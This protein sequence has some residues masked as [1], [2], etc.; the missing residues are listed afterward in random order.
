MTDWVEQ[1]RDVV[2]ASSCAAVG[3]KIG[4]SR[5]AISHIYHERYGASAGR[6]KAAFLDAFG[7]G[8]DCPHLGETIS[9]A[10]CADHRSG[11][12]PTSNPARFK[13]WTACQ[14]CP[15]NPQKRTSNANR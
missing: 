3:R 14:A 5:V 1:L 4:Y 6:I 15:L 7:N 10:E 8:P 2:D 9:P 11:P 12:M 13:H